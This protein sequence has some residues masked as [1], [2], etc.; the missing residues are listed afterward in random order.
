MGAYSLGLYSYIIIA[1][2]LIALCISVVLRPYRKFKGVLWVILLEIA[3]AEWAFGIMFEAAATT[4]AL[5][6]LWSAIAFIGTCAVLPFF[7]LFAAEYNLGQNWI[8]RKVL[9]LF[10]S[11]FRSS[12][13]AL[14]LVDQPA[15]L[16]G[17]E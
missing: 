8:Y 16:A 9:I 15:T 12:L 13:P 5:K 1:T 4:I 11:T 14:P 7:F 2:I 3:V 17:R 6:Q 10:C